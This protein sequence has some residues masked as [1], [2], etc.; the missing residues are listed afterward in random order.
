MIDR[1]APTY[2]IKRYSNHIGI[3][4]QKIRNIYLELFIQRRR[5]LVPGWRYRLQMFHHIPPEIS[6]GWWIPLA[7]SKDPSRSKPACFCER[8]LAMLSLTL[9]CSAYNS[10]HSCGT[11]NEC[12][13]KPRTSFSVPCDSEW[14]ACQNLRPVGGLYLYAISHLRIRLL[15]DSAHMVQP[16]KKSF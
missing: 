7:L 9:V 16:W 2:M 8:A 4:C 15:L 11:S 3:E 12:R 1:N 10:S 5:Q 14:R 6:I 13:N